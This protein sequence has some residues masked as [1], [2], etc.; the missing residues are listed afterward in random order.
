MDPFAIVY[1]HF[2][3]HMHILDDYYV[4]IIPFMVRSACFGQL[5]EVPGLVVTTDGMR[6][7]VQA[8]VLRHSGGI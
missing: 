7:A 5:S 6:L 2:S 1:P 3:A 8:K 4:A